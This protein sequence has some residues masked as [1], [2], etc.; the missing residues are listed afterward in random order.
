VPLPP[1]AAELQCTSWAALV[2]KWELSHPA[3]TV[4]I[5]ATRRADH[6]L[7]NMEALRGPLPDLRAR[8]A[9]G[10]EIERALGA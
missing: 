2:L 1:L 10:A 4:A 8:A 7:Q 9:L 3:V 6:C 5:P